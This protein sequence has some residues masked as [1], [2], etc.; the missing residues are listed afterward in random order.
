MAVELEPNHMAKLGLL[1]RPHHRTANVLIGHLIGICSHFGVGFTVRFP[2]AIGSAACSDLVE[3]D[4][5]ALDQP[6]RFGKH[7]A[8]DK[9]GRGCER[10]M[11]LFCASVG[12]QRQN[13]REVVLIKVIRFK[14]PLKALWN[15]PIA[16]VQRQALANV[17]DPFGI[18]VAQIQGF[19]YLIHKGAIFGNDPSAEPMDAP[20]RWSALSPEA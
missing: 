9:F 14:R 3:I 17:D 7:P 6:P 5:V 19:E 4:A 18:V 12:H 8:G 16:I 2:S 20:P 11:A 13:F 10:L 15:D 1:N